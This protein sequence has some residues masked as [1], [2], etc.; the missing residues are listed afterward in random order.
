MFTH[1]CVPTGKCMI[2]RMAN[3]VPD[4]HMMKQS[5]FDSRGLNTEYLG[6]LV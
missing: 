2:Y 3:G 6:I 5:S 1:Y 4:T